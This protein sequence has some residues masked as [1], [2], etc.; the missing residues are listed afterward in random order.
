M[1]GRAAWQ[2]EA[3]RQA[4]GCNFPP[5]RAV[6]LAAAVTASQVPGS[7]GALALYLLPRY[8][9][10]NTLD[11]P[12]QYKQQASVRI[13]KQPAD[14]AGCRGAACPAVAAAVAAVTCCAVFTCCAAFMGAIPRVCSNKLTGG[15]EAT[16]LLRRAR[17]M[18]GSWRR[19][20]R[21]RC[22][23]P[24]SSARCGSA[25]GSRRPA[26]CGAAASSWTLLGTCSSRS[27]EP[28]RAGSSH[29]VCTDRL[30]WAGLF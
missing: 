18:S 20:R 24:T 21:V 3:G 9:L 27:G 19:A 26:G 4:A 23:G 22:A 12:I 11:V 6:I 30:R 25:C 7:G 28:Q 14:L 16:T 10:V 8:L 29:C 17:S 13:A 2:A 5:R 1:C 15:P